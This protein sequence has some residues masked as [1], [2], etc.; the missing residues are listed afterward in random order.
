MEQQDGEVTKDAEL[1]IDGM[2]I[3]ETKTKGG[4]DFFEQ[5][6]MKWESPPNAKNF[7]I[8]VSESP[9][10]LTVTQIEV[11]LNETLV[12]RSFLQPRA[13]IIEEYAEY[14]VAQTRMYLVNYEAL[15]RQLDG[16][17][18]AGTGIY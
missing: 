16:D 11:K 10:R 14:A 2:L 17:D 4:R 18:R 7:T 12:F 15:M 1:E 9:Y 6:Y 8:F 5:F 3:D 13:E